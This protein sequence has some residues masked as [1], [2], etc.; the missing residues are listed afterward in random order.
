MAGSDRRMTAE[1]F[2]HDLCQGNILSLR[3]RFQLAAG[4]WTQN[5]RGPQAAHRDLC[6][7]PEHEAGCHQIE[8]ICTR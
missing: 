7:P 5:Y 6:R 2:D 8:M 4:P 1:V 3:I